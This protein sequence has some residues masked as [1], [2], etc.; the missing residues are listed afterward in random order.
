[1]LADAAARSDDTSSAASAASFLACLALPSAAASLQWHDVIEEEVEA[2][3]VSLRQ[4]KLSQRKYSVLLA[5][6][7]Q[8]CTKEIQCT[9][10]EHTWTERLRPPARAHLRHA[11]LTPLRG[12]PSSAARQRRRG[13]LPGPRAAAAAL[14]STGGTWRSEAERGGDRQWYVAQ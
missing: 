4:L 7:N 6:H 2:R 11:P 3:W 5:V 8:A 10:S 9:A 14:T 12:R 1:V 13:P